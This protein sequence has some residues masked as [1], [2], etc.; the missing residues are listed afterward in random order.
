ML[1]H[2]GPYPTRTPD[3]GKAFSDHRSFLVLTAVI[4]GAQDLLAFLE[5]MPNPHLVDTKI[6]WREYI[7]INIIFIQT[8]LIL[9]I[10]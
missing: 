3:R 8:S 1:S 10:L 4:L 5:S 6:P 2:S 7:Y 9:L